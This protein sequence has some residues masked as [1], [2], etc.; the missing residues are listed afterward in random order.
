ML[1]LLKRTITPERRGSAEVSKTM[2]FHI[3]RA[4]RERYEISDLLFSYVGNVVFAN[5]AASRDLARRINEVRGTAPDTESVVHAGALFAMGLID[6]LSHA[7]VAFYRKSVDPS[8]LSEA[9]AWFASQSSEREVRR[10]LAAFTDQFPNSGIFTGKESVAQ[11]LSGSTDGLFHSEAAFEEMLL[12][13]LANANPAFKPFREFFDE[14]HLRAHTA[15]SGVTSSF[16]DFF[17]TRPAFSPSFSSLLDALRAPMLASP[18]SLSGQLAYIRE[19]WA[20]YLGADLRR[21]LLAIDVLKEEDV[22]IWMRFHPAGSETEA[23]RRE[24][25]IR[26]GRWSELAEWEPG[27]KY[28]DGPPTYTQEARLNEY[29]AF[30]RDEDWMPT[31]VLLAKSTYVWLEQL[32]K[33]YGRHIH[34]LDQIPPEELDLIKGRGLNGLWLIGI[35]ERSRAS[36]KIKHLRGQ[37]DAVAS[38][39]SLADYRIADD[40]GGNAAYEVLRDRAAAHGIRLA[41]DMVPNHMGID[42]PWVT[43]HPEWFLGRGDAPYPSYSFN[44]PDLSADP[45]V[46][47]KLEDHYYDQTDAA[48][49]FRLR[50]HRSGRTEFIYHGNDGTSFAWNDTAQL[51]YSKD[52]VREQV[53]RTI[54]DVARLFPIIRFD[55]AMVLA[56]KHVQRLWFPLPGTGGSIPSRAEFAMSQ[57]EFD[58][59]M[60]NEFWREVVDRV[61]AEVPGTL[62]LAEAFWLL[63]GYFVRTLGMHRV[64][65]SAFMNMLRDEENAKYRTVIKNTIEFDPD[66]LKRYV[67]FMSNPDERTAIDQFGSG[68]KYF[69]VATLMA[70]LPGLPMFGH[71]QIE[72]FTEKYGME[73][74]RARYEEWPNEDL[75][76]RHNRE[77]A[78]LLKGRKLFAE[79]SNFVLYDFWTG[80][81]SVDENVYVYSNRLSDE[82]GERRALIIFNNRFGNTRGTVHTSAASM[83]K[84]TGTLR[85]PRLHEALNLHPDGSN[86]LAWRDTAS[87]LEYLRRSNDIAGNGLTLDLRAYQYAVL[88]D[89]RELRPSAE[90]PWDRLC[91]A[92]NGAGVYNLEEALSKLRL[93][94]VHEALRQFLD[95]A[96]IET[97]VAQTQTVDLPTEADAGKARPVPKD[98]QVDLLAPIHARARAFFDEIKAL[99]GSPDLSATS[100]A[101]TSASTAAIV[102]ALRLPEAET[103]FSSPWTVEARH[104]LPSS[105][106]GAK[107]T[108][109]WAPVLAWTVLRSLADTS[110]DRVSLF[111]RLQLRSNLA[112]TLSSLGY[113]GED[114]WR[115]AARIRLLLAHEGPTLA[116]SEPFW[117]DPDARWL[118]CVNAS[119]GTEYFNRECFDQV[120]FWLH[121][122]AL[123]D[124]L[125][126]KAISLPSLKKLEAGISSH[127][128][129]AVT[130]GYRV[131]PYLAPAPEVAPHRKGSTRNGSIPDGSGPSAAAFI[132]NPDASKG[133]KVVEAVELKVLSTDRA[134]QPKLAKTAKKSPSVAKSVPDVVGKAAA[135]SASKAAA[136]KSASQPSGKTTANRSADSKAAPKPPTRSAPESPAKAAAKAPAKAEGK[137]TAKMPSEP[138]PSSKKK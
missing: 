18:D 27:G 29:E 126:K 108:A 114:S 98:A 80:D 66:I 115:A 23:A 40:L 119:G 87:G 94:P 129:S 69:G 60:P 134:E 85:Q 93:R 49:A 36:E 33:K 51:D 50:D 84:A 111:D 37:T 6:E 28:Y 43:E 56:K 131:A 45:S 44:G 76:S 128:V 15:Y 73:Y 75:I 121:L 92:L 8:V 118:T 59:L 38:A 97:L 57:S 20:P 110:A 64:Y 138:S 19:N 71:G 68:D 96:L 95:P 105:S 41:S 124:L 70:T 53:I 90:Q 34:K 86:F 62:L 55:A 89:W 132:S 46:E 63:E 12:L 112:E 4:A 22:A 72:A 5:V 48:V 100:E 99:N 25:L 1:V 9:L 109:V 125:G 107:S 88:L 91:D 102:A 13:W 77:I 39:Y 58:A 47:I 127:Q 120:L 116:F 7:L 103:K 133:V 32:S 106:P 2:E 26:E 24:R 61:A 123:L 67:N 11:W 54:L 82:T 35:W 78:P 74:K 30:S 136:K 52:F 31:V 122:P 101:F 79:S 81:G 104:V 113:E 83:D 14:T 17:A 137:P 65:N 135:K 3:S 42:S 16:G 21:L 10:L 130:S 117:S